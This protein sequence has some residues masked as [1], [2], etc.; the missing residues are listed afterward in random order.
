VKYDDRDEEWIN[1]QNE[2]FKLLLFPNEISGELNSGKSRLELKL[3]DKKVDKTTLDDSSGNC[4]ESEPIIAWLIRSE[5]DRKLST[6]NMIKKK[7]THWL[8]DFE[9]SISIELQGHSG[10]ELSNLFPK[11]EETSPEVTSVRSN[12]IFS[13]RELSFVYFRKKFH[14]RREGLKKTLEQDSLHGSS[15]AS[16]NIL[17]SVADRAAVLEELDIF[18]SSMELKQVT[19]RLSFQRLC[20]HDLSFGMEGSLCHALLLIQFG[21]L[22]NVWPTVRMEIVIVENVIGLRLLLFE[23][24]LRSASVLLCLIIRTFCKH[25]KGGKFEEMKMPFTSVGI[26]LSGLHDQCGKLFFFLYRFLETES[27]K[28]RYVEDKLKHQC[29]TMREIPLLDFTSSTF[30]NLQNESGQMLCASMYENAASLEVCYYFEQDCFLSARC[31]L[32]AHLLTLSLICLR[33]ILN[34]RIF[35][36][37][38]VLIPTHHHD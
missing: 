9:P 2:R 21:I 20:I 26:N 36:S 23:G 19:L 27:S 32:Y 10:A 38:L 12:T 13:D 25:S 18:G 7:R 8:N 11:L 35:V 4:T 16:I 22:T 5:R 31:Y 28:W 34:T 29:V 15:A 17:A 3:E 24:S 1:L 30:K 6:A 37:P 14:K 33:F